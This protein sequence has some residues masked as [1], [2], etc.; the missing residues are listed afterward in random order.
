VVE[1]RG[2]QQPPV[3]Q[4]SHA[5]EFP[6][7]RLERA[8]GAVERRLGVLDLPRARPR[9]EVREPPLRLG[10]CGPALV[11]AR[12]HD[13]CF[14][15]KQHGPGGDVLALPHRH[16]DDLLVGLGDEFEALALDPSLLFLD[17]PT[18]GL[19]P[20]SA[21][22]FDELVTYLQK[23]LRLTVIMIT[24]DLDSIVRLCNRV[25]VLVD[26]KLVVDT[27]AAIVEHPHPW[28]H[29]YFHGPR[30]RAVTAD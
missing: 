4:R 7:F 11:D 1:A 2:A 21:A 5:L 25:A 24:H 3:D 22:S 18:S 20:I 30:G 23:S 26:R 19:D 14:L 28:I 8:R 27:L 16:L 9:D 29:E 12:L 6:L 17:E 15:S 10:E 13:A